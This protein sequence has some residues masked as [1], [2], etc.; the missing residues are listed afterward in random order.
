M[1]ATEQK[2]EYVIA[3]RHNGKLFQAHF[4]C[5]PEDTKRHPLKS[6]NGFRRRSTKHASD[7]MTKHQTPQGWPSPPRQ[8]RVF[9]LEDWAFELEIFEGTRPPEQPDLTHAN[10]FEFY[11]HIGYDHKRDRFKPLGATNGE[12]QEKG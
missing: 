4:V 11:N 10:I 8:F 6:L 12:G 9:Y 3:E 7:Y 1:E 2:P 5:M